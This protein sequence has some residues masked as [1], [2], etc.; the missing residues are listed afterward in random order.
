VALEPGVV[1]VDK[2]DGP[3]QPAVCF[4]SFAHS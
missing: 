3:A 2:S 4:A 1:V